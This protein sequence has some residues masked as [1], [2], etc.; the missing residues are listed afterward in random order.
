M[1]AK[2]LKKLAWARLLNYHVHPEDRILYV[3]LVEDHRGVHPGLVLL[4]NQTESLGCYLLLEELVDN[5][6]SWDKLIVM[7]YLELGSRIGTAG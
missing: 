5:C 6:V 2:D 3:V 1:V 4:F 7:S